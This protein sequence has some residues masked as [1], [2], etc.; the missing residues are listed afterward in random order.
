MVRP[1]VWSVD[2]RRAT[3]S[4]QYAKRPYFT[5]GTQR[6]RPHCNP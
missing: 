4:H 5:S 1:P 2:L 3:V 6:A